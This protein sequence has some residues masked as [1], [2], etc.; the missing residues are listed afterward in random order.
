MAVSKRTRFEVLRRDE[1]TCQYCGGKAPD[2]ALQVDHV[3]PSA[4]GGS[5]A[6]SNLVAACKD[7]NAGK[8]SVMPDSPIVE[9]LSG[10]AAAYALGMVDK[11]TKIRAKVE[12]FEDY[13][14]EFATAWNKWK[15]GDSAISRPADYELT[16]Y[17]WHEI[18]VPIR[19]VEMAI[20]KAMSNAKQYGDHPEFSYMAGIVWKLIRADEI[21]LD[22]DGSDV[23]V[24]TESEAA[25]IGE[26]EYEVGRRAGERLG[27]A[28][29]GAGHL[30]LDFVQH[31]IDHTRMEVIDE[32]RGP[33][34]TG[35]VVM[36]SAA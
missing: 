12:S 35:R 8:T 24:Y 10:K 33:M 23:S 22:I 3:V 7:C 1:H 28:R 32:G 36:R 17:R 4:L 25:E 27:S 18:G 21:D 26:H 31:H 15:C 5:D 14:Y 34:L 30:E 9:G 6:P 16:L 11:M 20:P 13:L 29:A 19:L 2:V